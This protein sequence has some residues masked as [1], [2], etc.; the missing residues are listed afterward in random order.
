MTLKPLSLGIVHE[1]SIF[2]IGGVISAANPVLQIVPQNMGF[3]IE[4]NIEPQFID[5]LYPDQN[6][7]LR[8]SAFNQRSTPELSGFVKSIS[9]NSV[10]DE[11]SRQA[12]YKIRLGVPE[13][14]LLRLNGQALVSGMPVETFIK[15]K[16]TLGFELS[17]QT[18]T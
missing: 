5:E 3:E 1:L 10:M 11:A 16:R 13:E 2:T 9:A 17:G 12:F 7:T 8:F 18:F 15:T 6:A 14:E 4:A